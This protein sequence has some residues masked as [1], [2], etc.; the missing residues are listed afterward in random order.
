MSSAGPSVPPLLS[1]SPVRDRDSNPILLL[2]TAGLPS[3]QEPPTTAADRIH[4]TLS[5]LPPDG[6]LTLV[7][8][9]AGIAS[10]AATTLAGVRA[11]R[12][13]YEDDNIVPS[14]FR[15]RIQKI[16][17]LHVS[18][19]TRAQIYMASF[20]MQNG[21]YAKLQYCDLLADLEKV[22]A[23]DATLLGLQNIDFSYDD[24]MRFWVGR[25]HENIPVRHPNPRKS[26]IDLDNVSVS[27]DDTVPSQQTGN[28]ASQLAQP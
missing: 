28:H 20:G 1:M 6:P 24:E 3:I 7:L 12:A 9:N 19:V 21:E 26:L 22:L 10:V 5:I 25:Q 23:V 13:A 4:R 15:A 2:H 11:F 14:A 27:R 16:I 18:V 8:C 17:A